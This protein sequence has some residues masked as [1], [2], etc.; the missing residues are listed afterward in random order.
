MDRPAVALVGDPGDGTAAAA[1]EFDAADYDPVAYINELF[2][3]EQSLAGIDGTMQRMRV[4][5][6][7]LEMQIKGAVR[8]QVRPRASS[9]LLQ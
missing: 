9:L 3:S 4:Q 1:A 2:P 6:D 7:C 5:L 8:E